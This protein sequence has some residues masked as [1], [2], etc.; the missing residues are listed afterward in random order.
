MVELN[1][2]HQ[3]DFF[4]FTYF[5]FD[6]FDH[7]LKYSDMNPD[8]WLAKEETDA[9]TCRVIVTPFSKIGAT[10]STLADGLLLCLLCALEALPVQ[11][12]SEDADT[13]GDMQ[14]RDNRHCQGALSAIH[15][16]RRKR[17]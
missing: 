12:Y 16:T 6:S 3:C 15:L 5:S 13:N 9:V 14:T 8:V 11:I 1:C 10:L 4:G 7:A 17:L 2:D